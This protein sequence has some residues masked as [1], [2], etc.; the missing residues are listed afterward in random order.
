MSVNVNQ[1]EY[2]HLVH[3]GS[4]MNLYVYLSLDKY[5]YLVL[6]T[7]AWTGDVGILRPWYTGPH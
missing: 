3:Q 5:P 1:P 2:K 7:M 6:Y 4:G